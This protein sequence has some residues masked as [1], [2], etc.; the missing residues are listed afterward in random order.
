MKKSLFLFL[1]LS[2]IF[3]TQMVAQNDSIFPKG[4][5][6][7]NTDN[8]TGTVWLNALSQPDSIFNFSVTLATFTAGSKLDWHIHPGGQMLLITEGK[9]YYQER[10]KPGQVVTKG[11]I[12]KSGPGVEHWHAAA[13]DSEFAYV[14]ISPVEGGST[15]WLEAVTDEE[16]GSVE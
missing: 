16:Y 10:G 11:D 12:V 1:V 5:I 8:Y 14:A 4:E 3:S 9:G 13:P 15:I 2:V 6:A 7:T